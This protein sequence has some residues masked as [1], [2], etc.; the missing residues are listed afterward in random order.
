MSKHT[1]IESVFPDIKF[2]PYTQ[3]CFSDDVKTL[4]LGKYLFLV[5]PNPFSWVA[6][7]NRFANVVALCHSGT[8]AQIRGALNGQG[9][10]VE[11]FLMPLWRSYGKKT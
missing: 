2:R 3:L 10:T 5:V 7:P 4:K 9:I 6:I 8:V 11:D 1:T